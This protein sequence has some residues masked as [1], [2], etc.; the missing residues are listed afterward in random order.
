MNFNHFAMKPA[1][2]SQA[3]LITWMSS[4]ILIS[5]APIFCRNS[6]WEELGVT[7]N[8][9]TFGRAGYVCVS[10]SFLNSFNSQ[11][12]F[13]SVALNVMVLMVSSFILGVILGFLFRRFKMAFFN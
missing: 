12:T 3:R 13:N 11:S 4:A 2:F 7:E 10:D 1:L 6:F 9:E 5:L 8:G